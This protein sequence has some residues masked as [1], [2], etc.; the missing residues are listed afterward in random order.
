MRVPLLQVSHVVA[1]GA[2]F[3][4]LVKAWDQE[5]AEPGSS[6]PLQGRERVDEAVEAIQSSW[7]VEERAAWGAFLGG[8]Q[9]A[10]C[11][12]RN[13]EHYAVVTATISAAVL[14]TIKARALAAMPAGSRCSSNDAL[15]ALT[16]NAVRSKFA[17]YPSN[18]RGKCDML[19]DNGEN[20]PSTF[21]RPHCHSCGARAKLSR[22]PP[23]PP[24]TATPPLSHPRAPHAASARQRR[25]VPLLQTCRAVHVYPA[26]RA[27]GSGECWAALAS[28]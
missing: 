2:S 7:D 5:F 6:V 20:R 16:A 18:I 17:W 4:N 24:P 22:T 1:D 25:D 26:R 14:A 12:P 19:R 3:F 23:G 13:A 27:S 10:K 28:D 8:G 9:M 11:L 21:R 15:F